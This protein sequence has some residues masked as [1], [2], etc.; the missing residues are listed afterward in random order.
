VD[1][2]HPS[3]SVVRQCLLLGISRSSVYY[4]PVPVSQENLELMQL[5]D[6]QYLERPFYGSRRMR[7]WL[8][9]QGYSVNRKRVRRLMGIMGLRAIYR[10]PRT[11]QPAPGH[12]VYPYLLRGVVITRVNQVWTADIT[13]IP[14]AQG[15]LYLVAIM[16]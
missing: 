7:A 8:R 6:Q 9:N 14:M 1:R 13:Y 4:Q 11:S 15:F 10:Y 3:L 12:Q 2:Q 5:I 16:D